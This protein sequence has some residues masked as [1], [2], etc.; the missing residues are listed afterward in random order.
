MR[1]FSGTVDH[2]RGLRELIRDHPRIGR[3]IVICL[4]PRPRRTDDGIDILP[5]ADF[6]HQLVAG[7]LFLSYRTSL[8][9]MAALL[10]RAAQKR[11]SSE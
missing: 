5:A 8:V 9:S 11:L 1:R 7:D 10:I 3:R 4:E 6:C 2:L